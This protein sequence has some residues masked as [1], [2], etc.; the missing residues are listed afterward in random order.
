MH[1]KLLIGDVVGDIVLHSLKLLGDHLA[2][3]L[4]LRG[5]DLL[6]D[7]GALLLEPGVAHLVLDGGAPRK[8]FPEQSTAH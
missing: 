4:S 2:L 3:G 5:A 1:A 8:Q 6:H 7:G